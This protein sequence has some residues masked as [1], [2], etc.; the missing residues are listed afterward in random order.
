VPVGF[1]L[2]DAD[3][4]SEDVLFSGDLVF[5]GSIGRTD[6]PRGSTADMFRSL[7]DTVLPLEDATLVLCGH[8]PDTTVGRERASNP[9][10][11]EARARLA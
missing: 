6:F 11:A 3:V 1:P 4:A 8:G 9:F 2:G 10:L 5:A 7:V